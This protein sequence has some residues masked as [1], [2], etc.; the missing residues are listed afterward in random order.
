MAK[1]LVVV[2]LLTF[3]SRGAWACAVCAAADPTI[4]APGAEQPFHRRLRLSLELLVGAVREGTPDA[5]VLQVA[6]QRLALTASYAPVRDLLVSVVVPG[7]HRSLSGS[8][9][10]ADTLVLGDLDLRAYGTAWRGT[11]AWRRSFGLLG[12]MKLPTAPLQEDSRGLSL[13]AELQPGC[14][15]LVPYLGASYSLGRGI[16]SG[17]LS[18]S[19]YLPFSIRTAPHPGYSLRAVSWVQAQPFRVLAT[20]VGL[21]TRVDATGELSPGVAD[22]NSGGLIGYVTTDVLVSPVTDLVLSVGAL[23]PVA[24]ALLGTHREGTIASARIGYDF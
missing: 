15:S 23:F 24:Q 12:G 18:V 20:R 8:G 4:N 16:W 13:P 1:R 9:E 21:S 5:R 2:A 14:S 3:L 10:N 7:L 11:G 17:Q 19:V 6:D 22:L